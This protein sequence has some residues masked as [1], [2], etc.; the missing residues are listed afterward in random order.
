MAGARI[1]AGCV[2]GQKVF[3]ASRAV[4]GNGCKIQNNVSLYGRRDSGR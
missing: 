4:L 2:L 1:G 3:V